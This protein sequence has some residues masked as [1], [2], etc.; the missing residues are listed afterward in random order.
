MR[1]S[2]H[3][4]RRRVAVLSLGLIWACGPGK[5]PE[6]T[7]TSSSTAGTLDVGPGHS[8]MTVT[9]GD[10]MGTATTAETTTSTGVP[11]PE[12]VPVCIEACEADADCRLDGQDEDHACIDER[13]VWL[14]GICTD[15][16]ECRVQYSGWQPG[17]TAETDC[18]IFGMHCVDLGDGVGRCAL[19]PDSVEC[20]MLGLADVEAVTIDGQPILVCAN[21]TAECRGGSCLDPCKSDDDCAD[22]AGFPVCDLDSGFCNCVSDEGCASYEVPGWTTCHAGWC[23]CATDADCANA[24]NSDACINGQCGCTSIATCTEPPLFDGT[25]LVCAPA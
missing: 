16:A 14:P 1:S 6:T 10:P 17:C 25:T 9:D 19:G 8:S 22:I 11:D 13:C 21:T 2:G 4:P 5:P 12:G 18:S 7:E 23:G 3:D 24:P 15:H 20:E